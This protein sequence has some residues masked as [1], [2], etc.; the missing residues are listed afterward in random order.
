MTIEGYILIALFVIGLL[1]GLVWTYLGMLA[2]EEE[3]R[4][5]RDGRK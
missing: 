5:R 1:A 2:K 3:K 4:A